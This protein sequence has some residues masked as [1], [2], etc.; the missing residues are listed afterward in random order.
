MTR[1]GFK[2]NSKSGFNCFVSFS[3]FHSENCWPRS[4]YI[5]KQEHEAILE[6]RKPKQQEL[7]KL[8]DQRP[9]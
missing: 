5:N 6:P 4:L 8:D 2:S 1:K 3:R 9:H 7:L